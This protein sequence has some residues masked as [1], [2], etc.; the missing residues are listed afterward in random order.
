M[1]Q[2]DV[3]FQIALNNMALGSMTTEDV[4]LIKSREFKI[5]PKNLL[6]AIHLFPNNDAVDAFNEEAL[7]DLPGDRYECEASD[8]ISGFGSAAAIRQM[9]Y[10]A[11]NSKKNETMGIP[12]SVSLK[13]GALYMVIYNVDTS[14]GLANGVC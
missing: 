2:G 12:N 3:R 1:R 11:R 7:N 13:V 9:Q 10:S 5:V 14:D 4:Q 8:V 6:G